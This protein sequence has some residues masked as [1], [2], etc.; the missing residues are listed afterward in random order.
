MGQS[1][2]KTSRCPTEGQTARADPTGLEW[3][4][5]RETAK[6]CQITGWKVGFDVAFTAL[7]ARELILVHSS[8]T[9]EAHQAEI[10]PRGSVWQISAFRGDR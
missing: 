7:V 6:W 9:L 1:A 5:L 4:E 2:G 8:L 3:L 10:L